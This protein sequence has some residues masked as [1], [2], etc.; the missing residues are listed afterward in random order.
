MQTNNTANNRLTILGLIIVQLVGLAIISLF[1]YELYTDWHDD[2]IEIYFEY[3]T[4]FLNG[5]I[6]YRDYDMEYPPLALLA[7][8]IPHW[9][10]F[11]QE[12]SLHQYIKLYLLENILFSL[13]I[14][15]TILFLMPRW[16]PQARERV[17]PIAILT[18]ALIICAPL[19]PWR[20][21]LFPALLTFLALYFFIAGI[22]TITGFCIGIAVAAKLYP[23][24]IIPI[25]GIF[26]IVNKDTRSL[27]RF[28]LGGILSVLPLIP[29]FVLSP[30]WLNLFLSYHQHR[31]LEIES[32]FGG[33]ILIGQVLGLGLEYGPAKVVS[34]YGAF[35]LVSP[36]V[37]IAIRWIPYVV[38]FSSAIVFASC[39]GHF[40]KERNRYGLIPTDS[41]VAYIVITLLTFI[42]TNKV[43]SPQYI[44]WVLPFV[45]LLR[46]RYASLLIVIF[47]LTIM[48]FPIGFKLLLDIHLLGVLLLNLRNGLLVSLILWM[49]IDFRPSL[50]CSKIRQFISSARCNLT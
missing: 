11:G 39:F 45:P 50:S 44:I 14:A 9:L 41:L 40:S 3:S 20:Y 21:D 13:A 35:H 10:A 26:L 24:F 27:K 19:L 31:G 4:Q 43:F 16:Q 29:F 7:F 33:L 28:I 30:N 47:S 34:N 49:L 25:F 15:S 42:A 37:N 1:A 32:L 46:F 36:Y 17:K 12:V 48:I 38:M 22:P 18:V 6:P 2:S 23:L 8:C 5:E